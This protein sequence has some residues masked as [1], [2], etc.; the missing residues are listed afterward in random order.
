MSFVPPSIAIAILAQTVL[1][2]AE[3]EPF[4]GK[5]GVAYVVVNRAKKSG[6]SIPS[7]V[8]KKF[9]FSCWL[10]PLN[11][12]AV[13]F[14][15]AS[16]SDWYDSIRAATMALDG[17]VAD[18]TDGATHYLNIELTKILNKG[19][20]PSWV[21]KLKHTIKIGQHDFYKEP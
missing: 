1:L 6:E 5:L 10:N 15:R 7:I 13:R 16:T 20:L 21:S 8:W 17:L 11:D 18:P 19:K 4:I 2:E 3:A 14:E 9:Q 12:C